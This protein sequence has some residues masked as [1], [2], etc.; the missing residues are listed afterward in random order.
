MAADMSIIASGPIFVF[1]M[2]MQ[3]TW[4]TSSAGS[5]GAGKMMS[6]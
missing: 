6:K 3:L 5:A 1:T 4:L 2:R